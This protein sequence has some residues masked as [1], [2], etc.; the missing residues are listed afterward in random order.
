MF[1]WG[2]VKGL[3]IVLAE[4]KQTF[5]P[6]L[7]NVSVP[8]DPH[9]YFQPTLGQKYSVRMTPVLHM[10]VYSHSLETIEQLFYGIYPV[11]VVINVLWLLFTNQ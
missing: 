7:K 5:F 1:F 4:K 8:T 11:V 6:K 3:S 2:L 10:F 9:L